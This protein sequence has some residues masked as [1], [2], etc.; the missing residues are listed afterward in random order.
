MSFDRYLK[1]IKEDFRPAI[2]VE[3]LN[4]DESV[5]FEFTNALYNI[6]VDL[7]VNYTN[8]SRRSCTLTLNNDRKAFPIDFDNIWIGQKFKL[9]MGIYLDDET[10][11]YFPQGVFYIT[12]PS[13][14]YNPGARTVTINGADKWCYLDGTL[15]GR[16]SGTY[17]TNID[18]DLYSATRELLKLS[19]FDDLA[20]NLSWELYNYNKELDD[21]YKKAIDWGLEA[22]L[23][24]IKDDSIQHVFGNVDMNNRIIITWSK[25]LRETYKDALESWDY[26]P[27]IGTIDTVFGCSD[28]FGEDIN[29]VGWEIAFTPILPDGTFLSR[30]TA[31]EYINNI[32]AEAYDGDKTV[33]EEELKTID[34]KGKQI[35]DI[36]VKGIFAAIDSNMEYENNGNWAATVSMLMHFCGDFGAV[37]IVKKIISEIEEEIK[38]MPKIQK[39]EMVDPTPPLLSPVLKDKM[40]YVLTTDTERDSGKVYYE[41][42][43]DLGTY[44]EYT[45]DSLEGKYIEKRVLDCP[46]TAIVERGGTLADILLE[47]ATILCANIY[48]DVNGR[49]VLEPMID[50]AEDITDTNKEILWHYT[51]DEKTFL[52]LTQKHD[53]EKIHNDFIVLGNIVNGYQFKGRVQNRNLMSNTCVQRIGLRTREPYEDNQY[54]SDEQCV[55]LAKYYAKTDTI[56]QKSGDISSVTLYHLDVNKLVTVS[57]PN[58]NMSK[59]LFL[60]T[61]FSLSASGEMTLNISS[62]NILKDFSVME[63]TIYE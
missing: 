48:Y 12:N 46:Y 16:L 50:T 53:F 27:D 51:V 60:I 25:E 33:T 23:P 11:Y 28:R 57:T 4:Q 9:W 17:Q 29:E 62:V 35:G 39:D 18:V 32:L 24:Q 58:N 63:A 3:W 54:Y 55:E 59:E 42:N 61:G 49:L 43:K 14:T 40:T 52:G 41:Y 56:L 10:P 34:A 8:G 36:Y 19:R 47:Y 2:K 6:D 21:E 30:D 31:Y 5:N 7:S 37:E 44:T 20:Y 26:S 13:D 38:A 1:A 45:G 15:Y 22:Y